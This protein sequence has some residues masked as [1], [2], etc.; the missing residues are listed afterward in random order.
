MFRKITAITTLLCFSVVL[1]GCYTENQITPE[2]ARSGDYM[3]VKIVTNDGEV[4]KFSSHVLP[5]EEARV[6]GDSIVGLCDSTQGLQVPYSIPLLKVSRVYVQTTDVAG[7]ILTTIGVAAGLVA[8]FFIVVALT[9]KSCPFVYSFDGSRYVFDGEPYGGAI[10]EALKRTDW[11]RLDSL[12][13][14]DNQYRLLLA[15]E[16]D[17]TQYTD[18]FKLCVVD[19]DTNTDVV[20]DADGKPYTIAERLRPVYIHDSHG[21]NLMKWLSVKDDVF[22]ETDLSSRD[23][24]KN[25]DLR[26]TIM[27][28]FTKPAGI[29][30]GK[31]LVSAS[32]TL[33]GSQM[34]KRMTELRGSA[35]N[36][37]FTALKN[38]AFR[39]LV[40]AWDE[41]EEL[42]KL[43]VKV[44]VSGKWRTRGWI[45][46]GGPFIT[47]ERV[48]PL[49]LTGVNGD[50]VQVMIAPPA[51]FWQLNSFNMD[52]SSEPTPTVREFGAQSA[53]GDNG[54]DLRSNLDSTDG[55][56]YVCSR[57][58]QKAFLVFSVPD[59]APGTARTIFA[60]VS[61]YYDLHLT[62][63]GSPKSDI[64]QRIA[65][66]PGFPVRFAIEEY[67]K[68]QSETANMV[69]PGHGVAK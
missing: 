43:K 14:V 45:T 57:T 16:V 56:Y 34:L 31:L 60:K 59:Q 55:R 22:W 42:Y 35:V 12:K 44:K 52:Y 46:G 4:V 13:A 38:P 9:K 19:H 7:A 58:G 32:T 47:E 62:A 5:G 30:A 39:H 41:R 18:E 53:V 40:N 15:N 61:G 68:W 21:T 8:V 17:E 1:W 67:H 27:F 50:T 28:G 49:D 20:L 48:V 65:Y 36:R 64:L 66:E 63:K 6:E 26:D 29:T 10:C 54:A 33:W 23:A 3:I 69:V 25:A 51:G 37:W 2:Q 24:K 11:C